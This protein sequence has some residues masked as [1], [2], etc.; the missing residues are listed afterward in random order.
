M[1]KGMQAA[2]VRGRGVISIETIPEP[3]IGDYDAL[4]Q[5]LAC[6]VCTGTDAHI[7]HGQ[8]PFLAPYPFVL[9]HESIGRVVRVGDKVRHLNL[10]DLVLRPTALRQADPQTGL[11]SQWGGFAGLGLVADSQAIWE[12]FPHPGSAALPAFSIA[13][14]VVPSNFDPVDAGMFITF[15]ETLS[16]MHKLGSLLGCSVVVLGTGPV[17]LCFV[18]IAKYLGAA[19]V[20]AV[21]RR[22]D[23]LEL[24]AVMGSDVGINTATDDLQTSI[25]NLTD[26]KGADVIVEA[27]GNT[28]LLQ[29]STRALAKDGQLAIYGVSP[30]METTM[31]WAGTA[32]DWQLRLIQPREEEV[33]DL[34]LD[35]VR[36]GFIDLRA[37]VTHVMP[38]ARI[39]D[40]FDLIAGKEAL[41]ITIAIA[42]A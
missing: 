19:C 27:I 20:I 4:V 15:K 25:L 33:H 32:S 24:A 2:V 26:G 23:R 6:G 9:G 3:I 22:Q 40:A 12:D 35:L 21:G 38:L 41:K 29:Q 42:T 8:F 14:Q 34:A 10:D 31:S 7:L 18:R 17:G 5:I 39:G 28:D 13:Q 16:W 11:G 37:F 36:L 1:S 30:T